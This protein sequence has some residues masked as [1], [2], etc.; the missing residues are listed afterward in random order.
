MSRCR[1]VIV[2]LLGALPHAARPAPPTQPASTQAS[3]PTTTQATRP[4]RKP[5]TWDVLYGEK[6]VSFRGEYLR[7]E[8]W[9]DDRHWLERRDGRLM[10][11]EALTGKSEPAY[12]DAALEAALKRCGD[13]DDDTARSKARRPDVWS[14]DRSCVLI[15][16]NGHLYFYR[17]ANRR[18]V[19]L[20]RREARRRVVGLTRTGRYAVFVIDNDLYAI[21]TR[22]GRQ[23]RLTRDGGPTRLN[24]ILDWVYQEEIYGRGRWRGWWASDDER[25]I[26]FLQLDESEVPGYAIL[27]PLEAHPEPQIVRYPK[28][29]EPN[30]RVRLAVVSPAGGKPQRVDLDRYGSQILITHV[31]FAPDGRLVFCV[32]DREQTWLDLCVA[33][34]DRGRVRRLLREHG[35]AWTEFLQAPLWLRDGSFLWL[36]ERD[37]W[38]HLY[39][40]DANGRRLAR[41]TRGDWEIRTLYGVDD[42]QR[43]AFFSATRDTRLQNHVYRVPLDGGSIERLTEPGFSHRVQFSPGLRLFV[44]TYSNR[45]TPPRVMLRWSD[46]QLVRVLS[47]EKLEALDE[48][49]WTEPKLVRIPARDGFALHAMIIEPPRIDPDRRY[50]VWCEVYAGP[51]LQTVWDSWGGGRMMA[52]QL[53]AGRGVIVVRTDPRSAC[54]AG[55]VWRWQAWRRLGLLELRDIEDV[56][57]WVLEHEPA[58]PKRVGITG[59]S[60]GGFMTSYAMTHSTLFSA[61]V[62][63]APVTDWHNY[64]TFYTE[65]YML[66]PRRNPRGYEAS[67]VWKAA[68]N[69][70]GRLLIVHGSIDDN[71][72]FQNTAQLI[73]ALQK[74]E[75]IFDLMVYPRDRHGIGHG[76]KHYRR[77][78]WDWLG[79]HLGLTD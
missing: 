36:S 2:S 56:I 33:D 73:D 29:G 11:V 13:F 30:P 55:A 8:G 64:D 67:S 7:I 60:Y 75:K 3:R 61:G 24:G 9:L 65:R 40:Y 5:L 76:W 15:R 51:G 17:F 49:E 27:N 20:T 10:K 18:L 79:A 71:V 68:G 22:T 43:Y 31:S 78:R 57:R 12:D 48:Y 38:R 32:Q 46:G 35:P 52:D 34:P 72:H 28:A 6:R 77:L 50:A 62:A 25:R 39:R 21:E 16:H 70:H 26:A 41:L 45:V 42:H 53:L 14:G 19:R 58:D 47:D 44:D 69:L 59:H 66:T 74:H 23:R 63:G 54:G 1:I 4:A 37:G